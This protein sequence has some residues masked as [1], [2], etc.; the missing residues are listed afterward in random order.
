MSDEDKYEKEKAKR[1]GKEKEKEKSIVKLGF[2]Q[3]TIQL[4]LQ[5]IIPIKIL[6]KEMKK[7]RK[8]QQIISSIKEVG[9]IEPI[10]VSKEPASI[11]RYI[12]LDG[13]MRLEA[14][15]QIG[16]TQTIC[17][18]STD[19]ETFTYNKYISRQ[20]P[21]QEHR[22]ILEAIKSGVPEEKIAQALNVDVK[23][24]IQKRN[25]LNGICS[26]AIE[27]LKDKMLARG[28]FQVLKKMRATRQIESAM[29]MIDSNAFTVPYAR[30]L[31][32]TTPPEQ[33]IKINK[34]KSTNGLSLEKRASMQ[35]NLARLEREYNL[36]K[37]E[38][39]QKILVLQFAKN[40][41]AR[42]L[43]NAQV[44]RFLSKNYPDMLE[45]FQKISGM[46]SLNRPDND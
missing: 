8:F 43:D 44:V 7:S 4:N 28:V 10:V 29:L 12:L 32:E 37:D 14:L 5:N 23:N 26:E 46:T 21:I 27:L 45:E 11:D 19:N 34:R 20:A 40:Y 41:L 35:E 16:E 22:M 24:I 9:I 15:K 36:I 17:L 38:R 13:H 2:E 39:G 30:I 42:L 25:L 18:I 6:T 33:L 1:K 3:Q 31:L